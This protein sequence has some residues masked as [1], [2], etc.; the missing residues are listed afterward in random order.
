[1]ALGRYKDAERVS[2]D[3]VSKLI[4]R[5][6]WLTS[7]AQVSESPNFSG[8]WGALAQVQGGSSE[9]LL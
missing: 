4:T 1:M 9:R 8:G 5:S 3:A 6:R 2:R 7:F